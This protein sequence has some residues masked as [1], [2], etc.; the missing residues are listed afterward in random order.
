MGT[1]QRISIS[2]LFVSTLN[3]LGRAQN[4]GAMTCLEGW[5]WRQAFVNDYVCVTPAIRS[6]TAVDNN[7]AASRVNPNGGPYGPKTCLN[8]Y[9]WRQASPTD[10]VCVIPA[11]R[12]QAAEDNSQAANRCASLNIWTTK[13]IDPSIPG[14]VCSGG[15]C[16][17]TLGRSSQR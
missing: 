6:Q 5:V 2:L 10:Y 13:F 8:G 11:T 4:Y 3:I 15:V 1:F 12:A 17:I 7:L 14:Q 9:V 16:T